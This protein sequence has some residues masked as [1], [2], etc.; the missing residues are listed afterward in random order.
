MLQIATKD[1]IAGEIIRNGQDKSCFCLLGGLAVCDEHRSEVP[2][3]V[4]ILQGLT[5]KLS[6][7]ITLVFEALMRKTTA[8]V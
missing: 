6:A 1:S 7:D 5:I 2:K 3:F 8:A 4:N